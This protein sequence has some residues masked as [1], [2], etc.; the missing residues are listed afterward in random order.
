MIRINLLPHKKSKPVEKGVL[1]LRLVLVVFTVLSLAVMG[2]VYFMLSSEIGDLQESVEQ[3]QG[4]LAALK[5]KV[6]E[7]EGYEKGRVEFEKKI[8]LI[9][10]LQGRRAYLTPF[11]S[12]INKAMIKSVW[13][14]GLNE[15]DGAFTIQAMCNESRDFAAELG[16]NLKRSPLLVDVE[17]K[18]VHEVPSGSPGVSAF[19]FEVT[20]KVAGVVGLTATAAPAAGA[21]K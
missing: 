18:G 19:A 4:E 8:A 1:V 20:G 14:T 12:E 2:A 7:V 13:I 17:V 21:G 16:T 10:D 11:I 9:N 15:A 6:K 3:S 5:A